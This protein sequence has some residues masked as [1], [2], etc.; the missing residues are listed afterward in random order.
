MTSLALYRLPYADAFVRITSEREPLLLSAL[1]DID[2]LSGYLIAPFTATPAT[3]LV[4]IHPDRV[5][6]VPFAYGDENESL[7]SSSETQPPSDAYAATF[8]VFHDA[9]VKGEYQKLV[10]A[11]QYAVP[12]SVDAENLFI[13]A[14]Q[15][16]PRMM[17]Q[18]FSTPRTG[19][20]IVA[21]PEPF[22]EEENGACH[23]VALAGTMPW[24]AGLLSWSEKNCKE[25]HIVES[26][27]AETLR[28]SCQHLLLDG[29][30]TMRAGAL[31]H[32][33][34]DFR[35][36]LK[37]DASLEKLLTLLHPTPAVCG[38]PQTEAKVF[39]QQHEHLLR[40][41]FCGFAGPLNIHNQTHLFVSLR[42]A[43][44]FADSLV[45]YAGGGIMPESDCL[46]EWNETT[47]KMA[48][49]LSLTP[50]P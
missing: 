3:P 36:R 28:P 37:V 44:I 17:I 20:W 2:N 34:T 33:R 30:V 16:Y 13:Q 47:A 6:V 31:A 24:Q 9:V 43:E 48:T 29:P 41:Y 32:L 18:L 15:R 8:D 7:V 12:V 4:C 27:I 39:I 49:I 14:V 5:E 45:A 35:F 42:C 25:Q 40:R 50:N 10:L 22:F 11:R 38:F 19:T 26:T 21:S 46:S 1:T 23:T